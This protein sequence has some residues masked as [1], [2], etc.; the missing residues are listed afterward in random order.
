MHKS[1][2]AAAIPL[3][4]L[5]TAH[6][7][8]AWDQVPGHYLSVLPLIHSGRLGPFTSTDWQLIRMVLARAQATR[9]GSVLIQIRTV[10]QTAMTLPLHRVDLTREGIM[11]M[12]DTLQRLNVHVSA[13][14]GGMQS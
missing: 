4:P 10:L 5:T 2:A 7:H 6:S 11:A 3:D 12:A 9:N 14:I 1:P 13:T 8:V